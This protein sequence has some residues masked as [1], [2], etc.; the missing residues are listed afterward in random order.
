[1]P[2]DVGGECAASVTTGVGSENGVA[3]AL[4]GEVLGCCK[5]NGRL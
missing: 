4:M 2:G 1:M 5:L 3:E